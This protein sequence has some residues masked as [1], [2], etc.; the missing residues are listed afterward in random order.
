MLLYVLW[1]C[2]VSIGSSSIAEKN[3]YNFN[4]E[5]I[6]AGSFKGGLFIELDDAEDLGKR[7]GCFMIIRWPISWFVYQG[8]HFTYQHVND[9]CRDVIFTSSTDSFIGVL[10]CLTSWYLRL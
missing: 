2:S 8:H 7:Y 5:S 4:I 6:I 10:N 1:V 3:R 9:K